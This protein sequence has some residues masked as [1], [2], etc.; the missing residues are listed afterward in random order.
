MQPYTNHGERPQ[1]K[2]ILLIPSPPASG[3][4]SCE[5]TSYCLSCSVCGTLLRQS[6]QSDILRKDCRIKWN[7]IG[8]RV[9]GALS[10]IGYPETVFLRRR[11]L[12]QDPSNRKESVI[13]CTERRASSKG[14]KQ[15]RVS[16]GQRTIRKQTWI[17]SN[18]K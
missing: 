15:S 8:Q 5:E 12:N 10:Q 4:Q 9:M 14:D 3:L 6:Q 2:P 16:M 13:W 18:R 17:R 7:L 11:Y 1:K